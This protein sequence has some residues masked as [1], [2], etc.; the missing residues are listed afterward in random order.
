MYEILE[1]RTGTNVRNKERLYLLLFGYCL[2]FN[3]YS[4][5]GQNVKDSSLFIP[6]VKL[7]YGAQAPGGDLADRFGW[8]SAIGLNFSIK[9]KL[10]FFFGVDGGFI[11]G[12]D[13]KED[14]IL[15]SIKTSQ[16][17]VIN[18]NG[19]PSDIRLYERGFTLSVHVGMLF[20]VWAKNKNSGIL[21]YVGPSYFQH[22]IKIDDLGHQSPQ[23]V[24]GYIEGYDRL[25]AGFGLHE[26]IGYAY[27]GSNR[28][29]NFF[30][31]FDLTQAFTK[32]QRSFNFDTRTSD[33][34]SRFDML[35]GLRVGWILPLYSRTPQQ[36]YYH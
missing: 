17:F 23:L 33:T 4:G 19:N 21:V 25:T 5:S 20:N 34:R 22:K 16:D 9:T 14:G 3:V 30:A 6:M 26:F 1:K 13:I 8:S 2:L 11:F 32:S 15:D 28:L 27:L 29:L 36:F 10:N 12:K 31:G 35:S 18:Q 7:S 24:K